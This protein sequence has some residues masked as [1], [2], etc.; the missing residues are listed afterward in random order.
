MLKIDLHLHSSFSDGVLSPEDLVELL[1][2]KKVVVAALTDHD[3]VG[4]VEKFL[5]RCR[6]FSIK[7]GAGVELSAAHDGV[8]HVLGYSFDVENGPLEEALARNREAR[9][10][11]N[12]LICE[13]LRELGFDITLEGV[14]AHADMGE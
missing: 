11:R 13:K 5:A 14:K 10:R 4:G 8:L 3:T 12:V 2:A 1:K 9:T 7:G 6:K